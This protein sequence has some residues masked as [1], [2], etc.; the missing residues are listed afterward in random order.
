MSETVKQ[1]NRG[2]ARVGAGRPKGS[3]ETLSTRQVQEMLDEAKERAEKSGKTINSILLDFIYDAEIPKKDRLAAIKL[4]KEH[5]MAKI[6]EGGEADTNLGPAFFLPEK[7]PR[8]EVV[9]GGK[10]A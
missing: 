3:R 6:T 7:H 9:N 4:W 8:L 1:E 5:T 2:G 10:S